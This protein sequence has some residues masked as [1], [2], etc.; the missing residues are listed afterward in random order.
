MLKPSAQHHSE[1]LRTEIKE[2]YLF[3]KKEIGGE[4]SWMDST[5]C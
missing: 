2:E 1:L 4:F 3:D 5:N